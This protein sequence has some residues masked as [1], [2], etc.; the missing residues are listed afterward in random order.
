MLST[1][2]VLG[3]V[4]AITIPT[5]GC[6]PKEYMTRDGQCCPKCQEGTVVR[7]D[8]TA[9]SGTSCSPCDNGTFMNLPNG[10]SKC[11]PCTFCDQGHGLLVQKECTATSD[12]HCGVLPG[13]YCSVL[14]EDAG[15]STAVKH[16]RCDAG[17][18]IKEPG[19]SRNDTVCEPCK[20]GYFS[21]DG[22]NCTAWTN[23]SEAQ[24]KLKEGSMTRDVVCGSAS[25]NH[26][27]AISV[28][29]LA[30]AVAPVITARLTSKKIGNTNKSVKSCI[31]LAW[32]HC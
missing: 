4:A 10:L 32:L 16:S 25:R 30:I 9:Q 27:C 18:R 7:K 23:C 14:A 28:F 20:L 24:V 2:I 22:V 26:Y 12:T 17:Q 29:L 1:F 3:Y 15:C 21:K 13:Y 5:L 11:F 6:R 19:T 31:W 8:C